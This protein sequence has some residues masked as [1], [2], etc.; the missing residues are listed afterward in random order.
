M[1]YTRVYTITYTRARNTAIAPLTLRSAATYSHKAAMGGAWRPGGGQA[2][3]WPS[4]WRVQKMLQNVWRF[5]IFFV[6]L[7][8]ATSNGGHQ[9]Y[10]I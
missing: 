2:R 10:D 9:T 7:P 6:P 3:G 8:P 5:G 1:R 4:G